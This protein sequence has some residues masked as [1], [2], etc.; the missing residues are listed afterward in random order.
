MERGMVGMRFQTRTMCLLVLAGLLLPAYSGLVSASHPPEHQSF[1][2]PHDGAD[3]PVGWADLEYGTFQTQDFRLLYPAMT[4]GEESDMA[5]NGPFPFIQF[6]VDEGESSSSYMDLA[7]RFVHKGYI[8][9]VH[10]NDYDSTNIQFLVSQTSAVA[11]HLEQLNNTTA[12]SISGTFGQFDLHHWG[13][14]GH[15]TGAAAAYGAYPFWLNSSQN[16]AIQP[17]RA[18]FGVGADF[19]EW[20]GEHWEELSPESWQSVPAKP[21]A[22]L[23]I[24]GTADEVYPSEDVQ[25]VLSSGLGMGWQLMEV[26][27]ADHYQFQD[28]TSFLEGLGDG[29]ASRSQ[30][31]Q[32]SI[33]SEHINAYLDLTLRGS[34]EHFRTAFNRPD[35]PHI[36]SDTDAYIVENLDDSHFLLLNDTKIAPDGNMTFGPQTTVN[37]FTNWSLRDGR[38]I[39]D[40]PTD[41]DLS[42]SCNVEGMEATEGQID[43]NGTAICLFPMVAVA[44]GPH[45]A[46]V[47][48]EVEGA[49]S[50][51]EFSFNRTD[52]PL[53]LTSPVPIVEL[54]QRSSIHVDAS[55]FAYDPDGQ[56]VFIQSA[57]FTNG[58]VEDFIVT[59][60]QDKRGMQIYHDVSDE[61]LEGVNITLTLRAGG[62]G[63]ID[64]ANTTAAVRIL[65]V[66]D[67]VFKVNDVPMQNMIEDGTPITV[68]LSMYVTDPEGSVLF[69]TASGAS[70]GEYGPVRFTFDDGHLTLT[71]LTNQN[72]ATVMHLLVSDGTTEPVELD[73]PLYVEPVNDEILVNESKWNVTLF[74]DESMV[75]NLSD[76]AWDIDGDNLFWSINSSSQTVSVVRS[77]NQLVITPILD[78]SGIDNS[79]TVSVTDQSTNVSRTLIINVL[80]SPD[81]PV[82]T[83][84]ELNLIDA[85]AGSL[86]WRVFDADGVTPVVSEV[87]IDGVIAENLTHSCVYDSNDFTDRCLTMLPL[88][89]VHNGTVE[90]SM[91]VYDGEMDAYTTAS[92]SVNM[93]PSEV[94]QPVATDTD[95]TQSL[96][97]AYISTISFLVLAVL[98]GFIVR[99]RRGSSTPVEPE[100]MQTTEQADVPVVKSAGLLERARQKQ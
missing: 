32:N 56:D 91:T 100:P 97:I 80:S 1:T 41:W 27:G 94:Q 20:D 84:Q 21:A 78:Y 60:D 85:T 68:N 42:V 19:T 35:G 47:R 69:G 23:F 96:N 15:G 86:Q 28:S 6:F 52:A 31:E 50:T 12:G 38:T 8:V 83:L 26:L 89:V 40:L 59:L 30:D 72:G 16:G 11:Q 3:F 18:L 48:I 90:V 66:D 22:G 34:H 17:P 61:R 14:G 58:S 64:Q 49:G 93:T 65:P 63:I 39:D 53:I 55:M 4:S 67:P 5:G 98:V 95:D 9:A 10:D 99:L 74:E 7:S 33:A 46:I 76:L 71:P 51:V 73:V 36:V 70:Q 77:T 45:T 88:P 92:I 24:S 79:T 37:F 13:M 54:N 87:T 43:A 82:L 75:L 81:A 57:A 44:P 29:D 62:E 25:S 2:T